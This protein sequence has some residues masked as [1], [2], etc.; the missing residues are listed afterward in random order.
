MIFYFSSI[1]D[2]QLRTGIISVEIIARKFAHIVE[3]A[4]LFWLVF[5][6]FFYA[7]KIGFKKS[8]AG[9]FGISIFF[10][11]SDE[12]HQTFTPGRAGKPIDVVFD[13]ISAFLGLELLVVFVRRKISWPKAAFIIFTVAMLAAMEFGMILQGEKSE[14]DKIINNSTAS[15]EE[16]IPETISEGISQTEEKE[17]ENKTKNLEVKTD[18]QAIPK[19]IKI[20]VPFTSQA[21]F[22]VWDKY[23]EES[24]EEASLIM[25]RYYID[26]EK[27][28]PDIAEKEIQ[29]M[30]KFEIKN[31]GDYMDT[32]AQQNVDLFNTFYGSPKNGKKLKVIYDFRPEDI[33]KYLAKGDPVIVPAAGRRLG[34]PNFTPPG[35][36]YHNLVLIGYSGDTIITNDPG[37]RKGESY[38]Y[39]I[40]ILYNAIH[41]FPGRPE[42]IEQ[43]RKAMIVLE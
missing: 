41:D 39:N 42:N 1:P 19:Q 10:A 15:Q 29:S 25:M 7:H 24:C 11:I 32:T 40:N 31:Q 21:P 33:K 13:A 5:R 27:L 14:K 43:G 34:N 9:A 8:L 35:P 17:A 18:S 12:F 3:Y 37:T 28:T 36:L 30:I 38:N 16:N 23:H 22:K 6:I 4:V 2:L 20:S 26:G